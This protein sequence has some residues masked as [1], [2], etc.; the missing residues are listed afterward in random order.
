MTSRDTE[1]VRLIDVA[2]LVC[3]VAMFI[4]LLAAVNLLID[5]YQA[6]LVVFGVAVVVVAAWA[7][8]IAPNAG[9]RLSD[10]PLFVAQAGLFVAVGALMAVAGRPWVGLTFAALTTG[11]FALT[12]SKKMP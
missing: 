4:V 8:W 12:R 6:W 3:E 5:G 10:P 11:V 7:R 9:H 1:R 2:A